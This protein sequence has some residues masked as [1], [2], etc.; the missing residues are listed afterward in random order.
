MQEYII[1][2]LTFFSYI[3]L[4]LR[5]RYGLVS[6]LLEQNRPGNETRLACAAGIWF[7]ITGAMAWPWRGKLQRT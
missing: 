1:C 5:A 3:I 4:Y 6:V 2:T 7:F